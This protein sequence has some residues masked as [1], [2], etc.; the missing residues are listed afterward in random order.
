MLMSRFQNISTKNNKK[1]YRRPTPTCPHSRNWKLFPSSIVVVS[2]SDNN[3]Q[4][5]TT[6]HAFWPSPQN[7]RP[8]AEERNSWPEEIGVLQFFCLCSH[9]HI[10]I[11]H[12]W[13]DICIFGDEPT[14]RFK[15]IE[16][17]DVW[18]TTSTSTTA[19]SHCRDFIPWLGT[20]VLLARR[21]Q[22]GFCWP[23]R[24]PLQTQFQRICRVSPLVCHVQRFGGRKLTFPVL[25]SIHH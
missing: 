23:C 24:H 3:Q 22:H 17:K 13:S 19:P 14:P 8:S 18:I 21:C 12:F 4:H 25:S 10:V 11:G 20:R 6:Q 5:N 9:H 16:Q 7:G 15:A 1:K 2:S